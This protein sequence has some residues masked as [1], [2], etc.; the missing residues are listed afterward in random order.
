[1]FFGICAAVAAAAIGAGWHVATRLGVTTTLTPIDLALFRYGL[2]GLIMLPLALRT[3]LFPENIFR[4]WLILLVLGAGAPFGLLAMS[5]SAFAPVAHMA[6]IIP[7]GMALG[8]AFLSWKFFGEKYSIYRLLGLALLSTAILILGSRSASSGASSA[9]WGDL[10]FVLAAAIWAGYTVAMR[11]CGL[12]PVHAMAL[13]N[14]WSLFLILP[15]WLIFPNTKLMV[16]PVWDVGIQF[17]WQSLLAGIV[18]VWAYGTGVKLIGPANAAAIGALVP[19]FSS[20]GGLLV[21]DEAIP[22]WAGI[23]IALAVIGVL[24]STGYFDRIFS[25]KA[26]T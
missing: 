19:V 3:G 22:L 4:K 1:M 23:A 18:A 8:V 9:I 24:L 6:V 7:G 16:A 10:L 14:A 17:L 11:K 13:I 15:L 20:I 2:P 12:T 21:L 25:I 26:A 5:G